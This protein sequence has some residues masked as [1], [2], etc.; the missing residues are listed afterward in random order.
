[1]AAAPGPIARE[2][3][4]RQFATEDLIRNFDR[5]L[6]SATIQYNQELK[7]ATTL[8]ARLE[9]L[10]RTG[11]LSESQAA[12]ALASLEQTSRDLE[13]QKRLLGDAENRVAELQAELE[14]EQQEAEQYRESAR[15]SEEQFQTLEQATALDLYPQSSMT[16]LYDDRDPFSNCNQWGAFERFSLNELRALV[17][18]GGITNDETTRASMAGVYDNFAN[19]GEGDRRELIDRLV[20]SFRNRHTS[21]IPENRWDQWLPNDGFVWPS[22]A[23][24]SQVPQRQRPALGFTPSGLG[25]PESK[26]SPSSVSAFGGNYPQI[27]SVMTAAR[28]PTTLGLSTP[29]SARS[30]SMDETPGDVVPFSGSQVDRRG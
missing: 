8:A 6:A 25:S 23:A 11:Q 1:M 17:Q 10:E 24:C 22:Q 14:T 16:G 9:Q 28:T 5:L 15:I 13:E 21:G 20:K 3:G 7:K 12:S 2:R 18:T 30:E 19:L 4:D 27:G 26:R 29:A